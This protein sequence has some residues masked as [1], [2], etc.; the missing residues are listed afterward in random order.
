MKNIFIDSSEY[1]GYYYIHHGYERKA[2][3]I[4][5]YDIFVFD[6]IIGVV[7]SVLGIPEAKIYYDLKADV[8]LF[9]SNGD[10][11]G[12]YNESDVF[13]KYKGLYYGNDIPMGEVSD[14]YKKMYKNIVNNIAT[15]KE[16]VNKLLE[17]AGPLKDDQSAKVYTEVYRLVNK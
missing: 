11:I 6:E 3:K 16:R 8:F 5:L 17:L 9:D 10:I 12:I 13:F 7:L 2:E 4:F 1:L 14:S 15:E